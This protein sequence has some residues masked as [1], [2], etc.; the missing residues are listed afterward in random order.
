MRRVFLEQEDP[1]YYNFLAEEVRY[2]DCLKLWRFIK[3]KVDPHAIIIDA[4]DFVRDPEKVLRAYCANYGI[5]YHE[6]MLHWD[7]ENLTDDL[8]IY[9]KSWFGDLLATTTV[10]RDE[11]VQDLL[12]NPPDLSGLLPEMR[13]SIEDNLPFYV[14]LHNNRLKF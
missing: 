3:S 1:G 5:T 2:E 14:E 8:L 12:A 6:K 7:P 10:K 9:G 4:D 13:K 11:K